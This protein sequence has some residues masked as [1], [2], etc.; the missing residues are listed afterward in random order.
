MKNEEFELNQELI[1]TEKLKEDNFNLEKTNN[2]EDTLI[3][4][5]NKNYE[6]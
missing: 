3:I 4:N 6:I 1:N 2:E 5:H